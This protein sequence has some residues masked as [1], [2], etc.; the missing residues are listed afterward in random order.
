[1]YSGRMF[2]LVS[3]GGCKRCVEKA[4]LTLSHEGEVFKDKRVCQNKSKRGRMLPPSKY[5][6]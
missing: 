5:M 1:M 2:V 4:Y 3:S 6:H